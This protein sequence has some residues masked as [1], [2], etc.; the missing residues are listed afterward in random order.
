MD[1]FGLSEEEGLAVWR[2]FRQEPRHL[3]AELSPGT[4]VLC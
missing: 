2:M 4:S 1:F 3:D